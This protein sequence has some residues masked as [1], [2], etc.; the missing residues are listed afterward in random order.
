LT[1]WLEQHGLHTRSWNEVYLALLLAIPLASASHRLLERGLGEWVRRKL[2][3]LVDR[4]LPAPPVPE[5]Q[6]VIKMAKVA[7]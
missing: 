7:P 4:V 1:R 2:V 6:D 3:L 5:G